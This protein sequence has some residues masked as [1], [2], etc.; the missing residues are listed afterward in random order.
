L[1]PS[2]TPPAVGQL[3]EILH[4]GARAPARIIAV[5]GP[6]L[7]VETDTGDHVVFELHVNTGHWVKQGDPY[8][9]TRLSLR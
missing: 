8:W 6:A 2:R 9:G 4:L 3:D 7:T 1:R 5:D